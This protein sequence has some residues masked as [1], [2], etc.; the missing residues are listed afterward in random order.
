MRHDTLPDGSAHLPRVLSFG[1]VSIPVEL[2]SAIDDHNIRFHLLHKKCG[3]RVRNQLFCPVC[4]VVIERDETVRGYEVSKGQYVKFEDAE[5]EALE[6][7]AN[8]SIDMREFI[9]IEKVDPIY[10]ESS[11]YLAPD[12]GADKPYRLLADTMAKTG[13][14][15]L[16]Q[17]VFHNKE[18]LVQIRSVKRG[19]VLHFL[20]FKNEIRDFD[21]IAKGEGVQLPGEQLELGMS[22]IEKMSSADFEPERYAD[23]YRERALA[24][25]EQKVEGQ[26]IKAVAPS[27]R[28]TG[29]V[30]DIFAAL[31]K[32]LESAGQ[33]KSQTAERGKRKRKA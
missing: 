6:A 19:L 10:F 3:S 20:F 18:S 31:K 22:L 27:T 13:R 14:V 4:K 33:Q 30:V 21:A 25:I 9:P 26:E 7:E 2:Y 8:R 12:K 16:A 28:R 23:E 5:L 24:M 15:A 1:L 32:S 17:T 29:Q 11:Y